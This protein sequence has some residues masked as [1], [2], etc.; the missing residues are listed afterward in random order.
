MIRGL[1]CLFFPRSRIFRA[2]MR[3]GVDLRRVFHADARRA[4]QLLHGGL[5]DRADRLEILQ[6]A[7]AFGRADGRDVLKRAVILFFCT[8]RAMLGDGKAVAFIADRL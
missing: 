7:A 5:A 2:R 3:P 1:I 4:C 8:Q 6:Q